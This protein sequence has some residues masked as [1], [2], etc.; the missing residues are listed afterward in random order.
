MR[1]EARDAEPAHAQ[2]QRRVG[3]QLGGAGGGGVARLLRQT[4]VSKHLSEGS[5]RVRHDISA[6]PKQLAPR[7]APPRGF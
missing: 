5:G 2:R 4:E 1:T 3:Q 7:R 6:P